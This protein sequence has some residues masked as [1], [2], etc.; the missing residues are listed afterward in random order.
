MIFRTK[1]AFF[2]WQ[3]NWH[4]PICIFVPFVSV[5]IRI[6]TRLVVPRFAPL[7]FI[8]LPS[9]PPFLY[10]HPSLINL[11]F[12]LSKFSVSFRISIHPNQTRPLHLRNSLIIWTFPV[13]NFVALPIYVEMSTANFHISL[14]PY[15]FSSHRRNL[16]PDYPNYYSRR[17]CSSNFPRSA[18][19]DGR[20]IKIK[21]ANF[22]ICSNEKTIENSWISRNE[23][24]AENVTA[25]EKLSSYFDISHCRITPRKNPNH[26]PIYYAH[27]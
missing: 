16:I 3:L 24:K 10:N 20:M 8:G 6:D 2:L 21:T 15:F 27:L 14:L 23:K 1:S 7:L 17:C 5:S 13:L 11:P 18:K 12:F 25:P 4:L 9:I 22:S 19:L 26:L